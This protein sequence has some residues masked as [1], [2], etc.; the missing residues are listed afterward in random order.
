MRV[1]LAV[2]Q[3]RFVQQVAHAGLEENRRG[4]RTRARDATPSPRC[5]CWRSSNTRSCAQRA[6]SCRVASTSIAPKFSINASRF[7]ITRLPA[8]ASA[9]F[10][11]DR[12]HHRQ[13]LGVMPTAIAIANANASSRVAFGDTVHEQHGRDDHQHEA[14][15]EPQVR[16]DASS[17]KLVGARAAGHVVRDTAEVRSPP[18]AQIS[19]AVAVPLVHWITR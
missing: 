8:I 19:I 18:V 2:R 4:T 17:A 14:D 6:A 7:T 11:I 9:P 15:D 13:H 10:A 12:D 3:H 16:V 5:R 1:Q